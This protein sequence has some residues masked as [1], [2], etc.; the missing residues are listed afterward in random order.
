MLRA[1]GLLVLVG[2]VSC[3]TSQ[4][5]STSNPRD[6]SD[7]RGSP[8]ADAPSDVA[9]MPDTAEATAPIE[10]GSDARSDASSGPCPSGSALIV[11]GTACTGA[12]VATPASWASAIQAASRGD[13]VSIDTTTLD[14]APCLPLDV[15]QPENAPTL[16]FSDSPETPST[17]GVLYADA[18]GPGSYRLYVYQANAGS[19]S[20]KF[21]IVVLNQGASDAH[22][23]IVRRGLGGT[24][25]TDYVGVGKAAVLDWLASSGTGTVTVPA[26]MRVLLDPALDALH[27]NA[28]E[29]VHAIYDVSLDAP[30]KVSFVSVA[31]GE[32]AASMTASLSLL[33]A[34]TNHTRGT[35]AGAERWLVAAAALDATTLRRFRLGDAPLDAPLSGTD[36]TSGAAAT[37]GGNYGVLY[38]MRVR[39]S[40]PAAVAAFARGGDWGGGAVV[41]AG[42]DGTASPVALPTATSALPAG[43]EAVLLGRFAMGTA[44]DAQLLS[45]GGSSLPNRPRSRAP[46]LICGPQRLDLVAQSR[47]RERS[48]SRAARSPL[49]MAPW[50]VPLSGEAA[51]ASPAKKSVPRRDLASPWPARAP[52]TRG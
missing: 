22:V 2:A 29:L 50:T 26:G 31:S 6:A 28:Q 43:D 1:G 49:A 35:F 51:V 38:R 27:A 10:A 48:T 25:S 15:C 37:L 52:P 8:Q 9:Q 17:D 23:A 40:A 24:P 13:V 45:A 47:P 4:A 46:A 16:L 44:L 34:D 3:G 12:A 18:I 30:L 19:T 21:P 32:D 36:A 11:D 20:R 39:L 14:S 5:P 7:D 33:P 42:T 41:P